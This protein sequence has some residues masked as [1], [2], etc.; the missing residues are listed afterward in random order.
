MLS[1]IFVISLEQF[2]RV[3]LLDML[4]QVNSTIKMYLIIYLWVQC[5][6]P[7][8]SFLFHWKTCNWWYL[9]LVGIKLF[10]TG[11]EYRSLP[12]PRNL[13]LHTRYFPYIKQRMLLGRNLK[14]TTLEGNLFY[15]L[16]GRQNWEAWA[17][18]APGINLVNAACLLHLSYMKRE[19]HVCCFHSELNHE[20]LDNNCHLGWLIMLLNFI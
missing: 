18:F 16:K 13:F 17:F 4:L 15:L 5:C 11:A 6:I 9:R 12:T 19:N 20:T 10:R 1:L 8:L 3:G 2:T 14:S 7:L